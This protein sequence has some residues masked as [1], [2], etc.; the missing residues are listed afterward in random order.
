MTRVYMDGVFDLFHVGHLDAIKQCAKL[1]TEVVIGVV[2]DKD[3][4]SYKRVPIIN[5]TMRCEIIEACKY[6]NKVIFPAQL[7]VTPEFV[8]ENNIDI[9]VHGFANEED[10]KKQKLFFENINLHRI[11]YS[12]RINTTNIIKKIQN[13]M[14]FNLKKNQVPMYL[15]SKYL[16]LGYRFGGNYVDSLFSL[17]RIHNETFNAWTVL[18]IIPINIFLLKYFLHTFLISSKLPFML[19]CFS[20]IIVSICSIGNHLFAPIS[21]DVSEFWRKADLI[22]MFA[23]SPLYTISYSYFVFSNVKMFLLF[24][25]CFI[26]CLKNIIYIY[27]SNQTCEVIRHTTPVYIAFSFLFYLLP[28]LLYSIKYFLLITICICVGS[29]TFVTNWPERYYKYTFDI[30]GQS[31]QIMHLS[32]V[33]KN[34]FE[35]FFLK[36]CYLTM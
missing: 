21:K 31:Q 29:I 24:L 27:N 4:E 18:I 35:M 15:K 8:K 11:D 13:K 12:T 20:T 7:V 16:Y 28:I 26:Y 36:H 5:E 22:G 6:V 19:C 34:V 32:L 23:S 17:F 33:F 10:Y 30:F 14:T 2:S 3:T 1:G 9:V 25:C